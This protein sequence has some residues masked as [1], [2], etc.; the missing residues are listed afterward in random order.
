[1][2]PEQLIGPCEVTFQN[3]SDVFRAHCSLRLERRGERLATYTGPLTFRPDD[4]LPRGVPAKVR[5]DGYDVQVI[6]IDLS[7]TG[8]EGRHEGFTAQS[9]GRPLRFGEII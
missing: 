4:Q 6:L 1:M 5:I 9:K 8:E 2:W 7:V 3:R